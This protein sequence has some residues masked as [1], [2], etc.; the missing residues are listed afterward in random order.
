MTYLPPRITEALTA[1]PIVPVI[2]IHE[3]DDPKHLADTLSEK[4]LTVIE[5][6]LRTAPG[7]NAI[8]TLRTSHPDLII[9]AGTVTSPA[10]IEEALGVGSE[11]L[12]TPAT[13]Q[14]L[15]R[16]LQ[17]CPVPV[18]PACA[19]A[20]EAQ[21]L[22]EMGFEILKFFPAESSGG[23]KTLK[24]INA[25]LPHLRFMP[26]GGISE[27]ASKDYLALPNVVAVGG[28]WMLKS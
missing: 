11:F 3:G 13:T 22:Y 18:I 12:V 15:A 28:S 14:P 16:A 8:K 6:T 21:T 23:I 24:S 2:T 27:A 25:P 9:G 4:G 5:I 19:T 7:L 10:Q 17:N 26:S 1:N 20:S